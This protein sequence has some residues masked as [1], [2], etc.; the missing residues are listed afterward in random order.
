M[1]DH[2]AGLGD[3]PPILQARC[4]STFPSR[5]RRDFELRIRL[6]LLRL[7]FQRPQEWFLLLTEAA[8]LGPLPLSLR[9]LHLHCTLVRI[10]CKSVDEAISLKQAADVMFRGRTTQGTDTM[11]VAGNS[12][13]PLPLQSTSR[14]SGQETVREAR[15]GKAG[16]NLPS[17]S[18]D[19]R[20]GSKLADALW[21]MESNGVVLDQKPNRIA[22]NEDEKPDAADEFLKV[23]K[24]TPAEKIRYFFLKDRELSE[25]KL[26]AMSQKDREAIEQQI[27]DV[28]LQQLGL[29]DEDGKPGDAPKPSPEGDPVPLDAML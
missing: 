24:M 12:R 14:S 1:I 29:E 10:P 15:E 27:K 4:R 20:Y 13:I 18:L 11:I 26:A 3:A 2:F 7:R 17:V 22:L 9:S 16:G 6:P 5:F 8:N 19:P 25:D 28:I 21:S 23:S